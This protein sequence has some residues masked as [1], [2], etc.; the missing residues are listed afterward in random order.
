MNEDE[1][2]SLYN[3]YKNLYS[4]ISKETEIIRSQMVHLMN[5]HRVS[6][7][8]SPEVTASFKRVYDEEMN[9]AVFAELIH[10][11]TA[12]DKALYTCPTALKDKEFTELHLL[13][14]NCYL[15]VT[16]LF[17]KGRSNEMNATFGMDYK[18]YDNKVDTM[19]LEQL[20]QEHKRYKAKL[21]FLL[22]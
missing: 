1:Q 17:F 2:E 10:K 6:I 4:L 15:I 16:I 7:S 19:N 11:C 9:M 13:R 5:I 12:Y 22:I 20:Q 3:E 18:Q 21:D 8:K 14:L